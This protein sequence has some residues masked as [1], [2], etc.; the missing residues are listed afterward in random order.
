MRFWTTHC[1]YNDFFN[2][3]GY[4]AKFANLVAPVPFQPDG[5]GTIWFVT[6]TEQPQH[7]TLVFDGA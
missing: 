2:R 3:L 1:S 5:R 4:S 6:L 7:L